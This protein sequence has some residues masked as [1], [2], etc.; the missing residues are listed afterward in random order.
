MPCKD[1]EKKREY[2]RKWNAANP[3]KR[4]KGNR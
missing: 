1:P 3:E 4:R 2:N